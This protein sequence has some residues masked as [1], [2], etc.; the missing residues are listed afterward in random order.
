MVLV[1]GCGANSGTPRAETPDLTQLD[2]GGYSIEP[3]AEPPDGD[4]A[5]G[6][7]IESARM[8]DTLVIPSTI[9]PALTSN[10][11]APVPTPMQTVGILADAA[12]GTLISHGMV[13]GVSVASADVP[14]DSL[15]RVG[16]SRAM[17]ITVLRMRDDAAAQDAARDVD[18]ADFAVS[19]DN[20]AVTIPNH[21]EAHSHW[22]PQVPTL[23]A[24][25]AHGPYL[26]TVFIAQPSTTDLA[27]L[28]AAAAAAFAAELPPLDSLAPT[29]ADKLSALSLDRDGMLRR[30]VPARPGKW[31]YPGSSRQDFGSIAGWGGFRRTTGIVFGPAIAQ[32]AYRQGDTHDLPRAER[33][34]RI[35]P[36]TLSRFAD[37][38]AARSIFQKMVVF[39][40][41]NGSPVAAPKG[42]PDA[43]CVQDSTVAELARE[44]QYG[45]DVLDGRYLAK[46]YGSSAQAVQQKA[47]AEYA[48]LVKTR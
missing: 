13:A 21:A 6:R 36:E 25:L 5:Y 24:S 3:L 34:A 27:A 37:A 8:A 9:D 41:S 29:P 16:T 35:G 45:C 28:T 14:L 32:A 46:V 47:A 40:A 4:E 22:R 26:V 38:V 42:V 17:R 11:V 23:A 15:P 10:W 48:L 31:P 2:V 44:Q 18:A 33:I 1:S 12:R 43:V 7:L 20:V 30:M 39:D 19:P